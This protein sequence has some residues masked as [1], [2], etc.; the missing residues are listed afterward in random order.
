MENK[1]IILVPTDFS[2]VGANAISYGSQLAQLMGWSL[3][4][5]HI[6]DKKSKSELKKKNLTFQHLIT[7]LDKLAKDTAQKFRI[8]VSPIA[9]EGDIFKTIGE[10]TSESGAGMVVLGTHGMVDLKQKFSVSYAKRVIVT[11]TVPVIL[12]Q[13][14]TRFS[15]N[16]KNIIFPVS[17]TAEVRQ[18][19]KWAGILAKAFNSKI[20]IFQFRH[21]LSEDKAKLQVMTAQI[22]KEFDKLHIPYENETALNTSNYSQ[23]VLD[24]AHKNKADLICIITTPVSVDFTIHAYEKKLLFNKYELPIMCINPVETTTTHWY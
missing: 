7:K 14:N 4:I 2:D 23:Q 13:K 9:R 20:H 19:V 18:K 17:V 12:V 3:V 11:C 6:I 24:Y 5:V 8:D 1:K 15:S 16:L 10:I 22:N 21:S